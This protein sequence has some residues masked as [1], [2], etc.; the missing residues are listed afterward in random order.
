MDYLKRLEGLKNNVETIKN[1][2]AIEIKREKL[3]ELQAKMMQF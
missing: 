3:K 2:K 1:S